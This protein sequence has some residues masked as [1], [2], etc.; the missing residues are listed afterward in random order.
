MIKH[1]FFQIFFILLLVSSI[2]LA[3]VK[4]YSCYRL[5]KEP[6]LDGKVKDDP[7]WDNVV[8]ETKFVRLGTMLP[9]PKPTSFRMGY[10]P[11]ALYLG[12]E[13]QEPDMQKLQAALKDGENLWTEDSIE[14][15]LLPKDFTEYYHFVVNTSGARFMAK[16][17]N[18]DSLFQNWQVNV[19][20]GEDYYSMEI[21]IPFEIF[22][23]LPEKN[24]VW[25]ANICRNIIPSENLNTC[26]ANLTG[27][28]HDLQNFAEIIFKDEILAN[29]GIETKVKII[30]SLKKETLANL[31][32]AGVFTEF[33]PQK[34]SV[35]FQN[36]T[37]KLL[38]QLEKIHQAVSQEQMTLTI[39]QAISI[40]NL[41]FDLLKEADDLAY[42][43][44]LEILFNE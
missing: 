23:C 22:E 21:R 7:V 39:K 42:R 43:I 24:K 8:A 13:C 2:A 14:L 15:F 1:N 41:S 19:H 33:D 36:D 28:Y 26:W 3:E 20:K 25:R 4:T 10:T 44:G 35:E 9:T 32:L 27:G 29:E 12:I 31:K 5:T 38:S 37:N 17:M 40:R 30:S 11:D 16:N 34:R 6:I 18:P